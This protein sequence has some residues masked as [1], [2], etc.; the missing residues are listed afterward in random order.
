MCLQPKEASR[1]TRIDT[2]LL[3]PGDFIG[4]AMHFAV[5]SPAQWDSEFVADLAP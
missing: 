1:R 2:N 5:V 3:P 4:A